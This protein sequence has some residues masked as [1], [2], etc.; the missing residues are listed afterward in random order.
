MS[1]DNSKSEPELNAGHHVYRGMTKSELDVAYNNT[2]AVVDS[3]EHMENWIAQS[4]VI[5]SGDNAVLDV[6]YGAK[7]KN[8]LDFFKSASPDC[9]LFIFIHGGYW[10]RN[11]KDMFAFVAEGLCAEQINVAT[12]GYTLAPDASLTDIASEIES[13]IDYLADNATQLGFDQEK[14]YIG[15]WSAGGHLSALLAQHPAVKGF[16]SISGIFDLEPIS[17]CYLNEKLD[18]SHEEIEVL[19]PAN[20][21]LLATKTVTLFAGE[22]ELPELKRQTNDYAKTVSQ[23]H[24]DL[25]H[26]IIEGKNHYSILEEIWQKNGVI[27]RRIV[28]LMK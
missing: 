4:A 16:I 21:A 5:R 17:K 18:L 25:L 9:G 15:G 22:L 19:S 10:Q 20:H 24:K 8:K 28:D 23:S 27:A 12:I 11:N 2:E 3:S 6:P 14:I 1:K 7:P 26:T 13:A